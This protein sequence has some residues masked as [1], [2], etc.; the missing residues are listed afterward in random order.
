[1]ILLQIGF[2]GV[3]LIT[4]FNFI[5]NKVSA[6]RHRLLPLVLGLFGVYNFYEI[7]LTLSQQK[8][9]FARLEDMLMVQLVCLLTFYLYEVLGQKMNKVLQLVTFLLLLGVNLSLFIFYKE[10]ELY[11]PFQRLFTAYNAGVVAIAGIQSVRRR[12][13][14]QRQL[15]Q[16]IVLYIFLS[17]PIFVENLRWTP[18]GTDGIII[19]A[20]GACLCLYINVGI[21][22][23]RFIDA[24]S[25]I[26]ENL[27]STMDIATILLDE[28]FYYVDE[29]EKAKNMFSFNLSTG[30]AAKVYNRIFRELYRE[31]AYGSEK[32]CEFEFEE[33][34]IRQILSPISYEGK[35][36]GYIVS[37]FD[38]TQEYQKEMER[39]EALL[40]AEEKAEYKSRFLADMSHEL[41]SPVHAII[42]ISD[43]LLEKYSLTPMNKSMV[44]YLKNAGNTLLERVS[45]ILE[46]SKLEAHKMELDNIKYNLDEDIMGVAQE[47]TIQ[48]QNSKVDF[49][50]E[51]QTEYPQMVQGDRNKVRGILQNLLSNSVKYTKEGSIHCQIRCESVASHWRIHMMVS[52]TG[53]GMSPE[54]I[55]KATEE[56]IG[57]NKE[58]GIE[59]TGLG[60]AIVKETAELMGGSLSVESDGTTGTTATVVIQQRKVKETDILPAHVVRKQEMIFHKVFEQEEQLVTYAF[61]EVQVLLAEDIQVNRII[62]MQMTEKWKFKLDCVDDGDAAIAAAKAKEYDMI[63]LDLMMPRIDGITACKELRKITEAP[64]VALTANLSEGIQTDCKHAGFTRFLEK[65]IQQ[66]YLKQVIEDLLPTEKRQLAPT[67]DIITNEVWKSGRAQY[68]N[69]LE[70]F[71]QELCQLRAQL[72]GYY[73]TDLRLFQTKVHGIKGVS[74]QFGREVLANYAEILEMAAKLENRRFLDKA[75]TNFFAIMEETIVEIDNEIFSL[76]NSELLEQERRR[77]YLKSEE[78]GEEYLKEEQLQEKTEQ[79][80]DEQ[81]MKQ[82]ELLLQL[83]QAFENYNINEIRRILQLLEEGETSL[84]DEFL[85]EIHQFAREYEYEEGL[86]FLKI[87]GIGDKA[88]SHKKSHHK[89]R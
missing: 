46:Y 26:Q 50:V 32:S 71:R 23:N 1:M 18:N 80:N 84:A 25:I 69:N 40:Y 88:Y 35:V 65:P 66:K 57:F 16:K 49:V 45:A 62:F 3:T 22:T 44:L 55:K 54:Q 83:Y 75:L 17:T 87:M 36:I 70:V 2:L 76:K 60:L 86:E 52:D 74:R 51:M 7:V 29:N 21:W 53:K 61:P 13:G 59:S 78:V 82:E 31:M 64:I 9:L 4:I 33:K 10:P 38:I 77:E 28:E 48:L 5:Y 8:Q 30:H 37:V 43:L 19:S 27:F 67:V 68:F 12:N 6:R 11:I 81:A 15:V 58:S 47:I 41:R 79:D 89:K 20:L 39:E 24:S 72:Q 56:Y 34:H 14:I 73:E 85:A 42:G 63:F